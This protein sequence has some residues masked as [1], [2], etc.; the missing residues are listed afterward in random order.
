MKFLVLRI[1]RMILIQ[2]FQN[3]MI[4]STILKQNDEL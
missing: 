3:W 4:V 2:I 1:L